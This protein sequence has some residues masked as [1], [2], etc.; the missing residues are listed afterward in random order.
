MKIEKN[1]FFPLFEICA[2]KIVRQKAGSLFMVTV[3]YT[4]FS[5]C[6]CEREV[7][8]KMLENCSCATLRCRPHSTSFSTFK[9][10]PFLEQTVGTPEEYCNVFQTEVTVRKEL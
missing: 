7:F 6:V 10:V 9:I 4:R 8:E 2:E 5:S 1:V 3:L